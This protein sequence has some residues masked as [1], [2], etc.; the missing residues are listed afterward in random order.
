[1]HAIRVNQLDRIPRAIGIR[2]NARVLVG[3]LVDAEPHGHQLVVHI[4]S[5]EVSVAGFLVAFFPGERR[6]VEPQDFGA[7]LYVGFMCWSVQIGIVI[8]G[9]NPMA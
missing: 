9:Y 5:A 4:A 7:V 2:T 1:M 3:Q 6:R 8:F